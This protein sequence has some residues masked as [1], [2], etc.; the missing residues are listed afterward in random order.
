LELREYIDILRRHRWTIIQSVLVVAV[1]AGVFSNL[2][3]PTY[4]STAQVLLRPNDATEQV[5][6]EAGPGFRDPGRNVAAQ[7]EIAE[8]RPVLDAAAKEL[9]DF[10]VEELDA[11]VAVSSS[12]T[13]DVLRISGRSL[14]P[15]EAREIANATARAYIENRRKFAVAN[16]ERASDE[17]G[18][19]LTDLQDQIALLDTRIGD[20]G[21][22]PGGSTVPTGPSRTTEAPEMSARTAPLA[23]PAERGGQPTNSESLKAARYAAAVQY[24]TLYAR[25]QELLV[26]MSLKR[27]E[28]ELI[29]EAIV[30]REPVS[31][32]PIRD[33]VLGAVVGLLL[34]LGY[35]FLRE[36]LDDRIRS[37]EELERVT[38]LTVLSDI[39]YDD[40]LAK[41][42]DA[43]LAQEQPLGRVAEAARGLRT[44]LQFLALDA[45]LKRIVVTS[46]GPGVGKS[47]VAAN[48]ATVYAQAGFAT[49]L[50][51]ADLR[52]PR[53]EAM[54]DIAASNGLTDLLAELAGDRRQN[55]SQGN[56]STAA[57]HTGASS[58]SDPDR[59]DRAIH[60]AL[61]PTAV[62]NLRVLPAGSRPPNPAEL[63]AS[64]R[65]TEVL[66]ELG[67]AA[68]VVIIDAPPVLAVTDP[69]ILAAKSD[70]VLIVVG[71]EE[72]QRTEASRAK[73]ALDGAHTRLLGVV[74][75]KVPVD[76]RQYGYDHYAEDAASPRRT[77]RAARKAAKAKKEEARAPA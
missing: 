75:N 60:R 62:P 3:T 8:S 77:R 67:S 26:E 74:L 57:N 15:V 16:L 53:V 33:A 34:G 58:P 73:A 76:S 30:P 25:Q 7:Q 23:Q 24:E 68:D 41:R 55:P 40:T 43:V 46:A 38:G 6:P 66:D 71:L 56:G 72:T 52:R 17:I 13:T 19:K 36:Q 31:P 65:T 35:A 63:L 4:S 59:R 18:A 5:N 28:A 44:N 1:V 21:I 9:D 45:P 12:A 69:A 42:P 11:A 61:V 70:G 32:K 2:R 47:T 54:F 10:T 50:V 22:A 29:S 51:S 14:D 49:V 39:P 27:G 37:R 48:L 20:G 64:R